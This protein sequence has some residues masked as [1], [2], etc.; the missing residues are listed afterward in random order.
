M[1]F[2]REKQEQMKLIPWGRKMAKK[3]LSIGNIV[4][5]LKSVVVN[6]IA[7]LFVLPFWGLLLLLPKLALLWFLLYIPVYMLLWGYVAK[8]LWGWR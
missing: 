2:T 4:T 3:F 6:L 5:S 8:Y 7:A 1:R